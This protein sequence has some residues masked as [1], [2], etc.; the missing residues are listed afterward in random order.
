MPTALITSYS[1]TATAE[2][3]AAE[4]KALETKDF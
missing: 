1:A 3:T 4:A 2:S